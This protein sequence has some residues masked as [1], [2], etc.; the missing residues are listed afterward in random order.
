MALNIAGSAKK[1]GLAMQETMSSGGRWKE[2]QPGG[3]RGGDV[4]M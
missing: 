3:G 2:G 1:K 4:C